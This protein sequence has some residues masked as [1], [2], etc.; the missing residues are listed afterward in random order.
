MSPLIW[1]DIDIMNQV[2]QKAKEII[3]ILES[4]SFGTISYVLRAFSILK[5]CIAS[6]EVFR[7]KYCFFKETPMLY[8]EI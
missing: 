4:D 1:D 8:R 5:N 7:W 2:L 3:H 6:R